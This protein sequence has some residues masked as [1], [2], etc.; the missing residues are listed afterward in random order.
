[1]INRISI[2]AIMML[3]SA[4][5]PKATSITTQPDGREIDLA[6]GKAVY[7]KDCA[8]CHDNGANGAQMIGDI[9]GWQSRIE[10]GV[11]ALVGNAIRGF[12]GALGYMP[13]RGGNPS[14]SHEAVT[15]ATWYIVSKS[16][17]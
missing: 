5:T 13:P 14:L 2:L 4:C 12:S 1:M 9:E 10:R 17:K 3:I 11:P 6:W 8:R 16:S 7:R 15:A